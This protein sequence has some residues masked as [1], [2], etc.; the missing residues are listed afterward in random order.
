MVSFAREKIEIDGNFVEIAKR[1]RKPE[2]R[3]RFA[4]PCHRQAC[5]HWNENG[6]GVVTA[7]VDGV[8]KLGHVTP[9]TI[10]ECSI[11]ESCRWFDQ[12]GFEACRGCSFVITEDDPQAGSR[13]V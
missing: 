11:R 10:P 7:V 2:A 13:Q 12:A 4:G 5:L 9:R 3:F 6:C 1:G 8:E